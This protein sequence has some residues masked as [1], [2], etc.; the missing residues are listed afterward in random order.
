MKR[1]T[2]TPPYP[3]FVEGGET[4]AL[5][6]SHDWTRT[7]LGEVDSWPQSL[8]TMVSVVLGASEPMLILWGRSLTL[9]NNDSS[10]AV[11][12]TQPSQIIGK[13]AR[14]AWDEIWHTIGPVI[15]RVMNT[16]AACDTEP[17][18]LLAV[19]EPNCA[20]SYYSFSFSP[21]RDET[22]GIGGIFCICRKST[23]ASDATTDADHTVDDKSVRK[24]ASAIAVKRDRRFRRV[25]ESNMFGVMFAHLNG[26]ISYA[27]DYI[28][29]ML[30]YDSEDLYAGQLR[31]DELTTPEFA[32]L[33][34]NAVQQIQETGTCVPYE[35]VLLHKDG[36]RIP[37][38]AMGAR[39]Q[40]S[41]TQDNEAIAFVLDLSEVKQITDERDRFFD[42]SPDVFG[43][44]DPDG[45]F[46]YVSSACERNLGFTAEEILSQPFLSFVHPDDIERTTALVQAMSEG[47]EAVN[48]ENR[49]RHKE[50]YYIWLSWNVTPMIREN[51]VQ[52][53]CIGRNMNA[54]KRMQSE[55]EQLLLAEQTAR[56]AAERANRIKDEFLAVVSHELRSPLNPIL[57]WSQ[58]LRRG[59]LS[60]EKTQT[61]LDSIARNAQ[62]QVQL[63]GDLLDIS[64]ILRGKLTLNKEPVDI[65]TVVAAALE[66]VE[67]SAATK[68]IQIET[69]VSPCRVMGD[70]VRLQQV[71]WN[72]LSNAVKFTPEGGSVVVR[73]GAE[74]TQAKIEVTDTGKGIGAEFLPFVFEHFLQEDYS[75]TRKF[76]GLGLGLAIVRQVV[77]LH[78]GSVTV[79]SSGEGKGA[80]FTV[81]IPLS[82][83]D[84][85][86]GKDAP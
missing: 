18:H 24:R 52:F 21:I 16:G 8:R 63:I 69:I 58:L 65:G 37:I 84:Q 14:L 54:Y 59:N 2:S 15:E 26:G 70:T 68:S 85:A 33:D 53:Y 1:P 48:F 72:L 66:T 51:S 36:R 39:L 4:G 46:T 10:A 31:W 81:R 43:I 61:A 79:A 41:F 73:A 77:E 40:D 5:M 83:A 82:P 19:R 47:N 64:R 62:L 55:K 74:K 23:A 67:Q 32:D 75:T 27:N 22:G 76:G 49:Y 20:D 80:T 42:L 29:K 60:A 56:E 45:Y 12:S 7:P 30:G 71:V 11:L 25:V 3:T 34:R 35:K 44:A 38:L 6:R 13:P 86:S 9:L 17:F 28:L 50:G 78:Q 57:G